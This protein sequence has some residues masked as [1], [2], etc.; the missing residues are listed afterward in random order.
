MHQNIF[1]ITLIIDSIKTTIKGGDKMKIK[2]FHFHEPINVESKLNKWLDENHG[3]TVY[4]IKQSESYADN[5][6]WSL[7]ISVYYMESIIE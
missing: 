2:F 6:K 1:L 5:E 7:S 4:H 3:I